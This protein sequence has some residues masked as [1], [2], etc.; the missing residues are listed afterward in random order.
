M[1]SKQAGTSQQSSTVDSPT[2]KRKPNTQ[3]TKKSIPPP[4]SFGGFALLVVLH[5]CKKVLL[6][7]TDLKAALYF[8]GIAGVS[9]FFDIFRPGRAPWFAAKTSLL[10]TV[11]VKWSWAWSSV[12]LFCFIVCSAYVYT[13]ASR[14]LLRRHILRLLYA[15]TWWFVCTK[16]L[17]TIV[18]VKTSQCILRAAN[19][20]DSAAADSRMSAGESIAQRECEK[21]GHQWVPG[22]DISGHVFILVL[23]NLMTMEE[24]AAFR[25]WDRLAGHLT[26]VDR[27][28]SHNLPLDTLSPALRSVSPGLARQMLSAHSMLTPLVRVL[29]V[30]LALL[31]LLADTALVLTAVYYHTM[32]SKVFGCL[33]AVVFWLLTYCLLYRL[34]PP[35]ASTSTSTSTAAGGEAGSGAG[36]DSWLPCL[37]GSGCPIP[38]FCSREPRA[39]ATQH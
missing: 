19:R 27:H 17:M 5:S 26:D 1:T 15:T 2:S 34:S 31:S 28:H 21:R 32:P 20:S 30:A 38:N 37:P 4:S 18:E 11:F 33:L 25:G 22:L 10:N 14:Q 12:L 7:R 3:A 8:V 13:N 23:I 35:S 9:L 29:F 39:T 16:I 6:V 36:Q 24:A